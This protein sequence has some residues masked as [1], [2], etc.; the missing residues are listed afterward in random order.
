MWAPHS[1]VSQAWQLLLRQVLPQPLEMGSEG[2]GRKLIQE[3]LVGVCSR[4][5]REDGALLLSTQVSCWLWP[6]RAGRAHL[7]FHV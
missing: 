2:L 1:L 4:G 3:G 5:V 7:S 6:R